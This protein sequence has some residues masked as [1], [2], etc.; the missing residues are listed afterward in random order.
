MAKFVD[1]YYGPDGLEVPEDVCGQSTE[2][3]ADVE[4]FV[5]NCPDPEPM[6]VSEMDLFFLTTTVLVIS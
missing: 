5:T 2:T 1:A 4:Y 3:D 6:S